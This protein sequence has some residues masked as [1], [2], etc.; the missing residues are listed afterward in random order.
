MAVAAML[1]WP[2]VV[3]AFFAQHAQRDVHV[4][5]AVANTVS[6]VPT[7]RPSAFDSA[8]EE[9]GT[10]PKVSKPFGLYSQAG[11]AA[12]IRDRPAVRRLLDE[13][14]RCEADFR[15]LSQ[16]ERDA[17]VIAA[18]RTGNGNAKTCTSKANQI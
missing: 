18:A 15:S 9:R 2:I 5:T 6:Y 12:K 11:R 13:H 14:V 3:Q 1:G 7:L 8:R 10:Q 17:L 16:G 4:R